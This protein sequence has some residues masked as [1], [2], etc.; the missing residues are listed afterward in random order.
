M[1]LRMR[2]FSRRTF[3][4]SLAAAVPLP[5]IVRQAHAASITHLQSD[6][7]TLDAL[8]ETVLPAVAL[9]AVGVQRASAAFRTWGE[10]YRA[11]AELN[12]GYGTSRLRVSGP[13]PL[14][15]WAA[16]L[17]ELDTAARA[18]HQKKFRELKVAERE[19]IVRESLQGQR[20]DRMPAVGEA[21][22][23]ALALLAHFYDS[24]TANDLCYQSQIGRSTCR[25]LADTPRKPLPFLKVS[26]R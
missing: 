6:P 11:E 26:E 5:L 22:H 25:R 15:R 14:T 10:G 19:A 16:Q 17:D 20:V 12:H 24:S 8:A 23:V 7:A 4:A 1:L 9:G 21:P 2:T 3:L 18:A 13:T